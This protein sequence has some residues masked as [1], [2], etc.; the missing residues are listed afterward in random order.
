MIDHEWCLL[1]HCMSKLMESWTKK[2]SRQ[3]PKF[4]RPR[5]LTR[6]ACE[7]GLD[8]FHTEQISAYALGDDALQ[9]PVSKSQ[10][11]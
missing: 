7:A 8:A 11:A 10:D 6:A 3:V 2:Y 5:P 9:T 4:Q 1:T